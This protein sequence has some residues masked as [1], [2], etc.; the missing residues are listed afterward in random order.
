[1]YQ[2]EFHRF[3]QRIRK[4]CGLLQ[5]DYALLHT[6]APLDQALFQYL[7]ARARRKT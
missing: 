6:D 3:Q 5:A 1:M 2:T 4:I 7:S